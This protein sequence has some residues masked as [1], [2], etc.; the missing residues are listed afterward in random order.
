MRSGKEHAT[1]VCKFRKMTVARRA[2]GSRP[3]YPSRWVLMAIADTGW[4]TQAHPEIQ[5]GPA[6]SRIQSP[7]WREEKTPAATGQRTRHLHRTLRPTLFR[8]TCS[9]SSQCTPINKERL[10]QDAI[11][12]ARVMVLFLISLQLR[13]QRSPVRNGQAHSRPG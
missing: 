10:I 5:P 4:T 13:F 2:I 11:M 9:V 8:Y 3:A 6:F 12:Y 1:H 7:N